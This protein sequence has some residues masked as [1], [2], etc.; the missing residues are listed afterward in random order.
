MAPYSFQLIDQIFLKWYGFLSFAK[1]I[2]R[3]I[4][5]NISKNLSSRHC[6]KL[7]PKEQF[8]KQQKQLVIWLEIKLLLKSQKHHLKKIQTQVQMK[9][10]HLEK[11]IYHQKKDKK[12]LI[13]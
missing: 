5:K 8:K 11:D 10:K 9:K 12:S 7:L 13:I 4:G 3:N 2:G 6:H 1:N